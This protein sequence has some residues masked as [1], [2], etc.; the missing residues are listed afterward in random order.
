M[1]TTANRIMHKLGNHPGAI[2]PRGLEAPSHVK[3]TV[4]IPINLLLAAK[5]KVLVAWVANRPTAIAWQKRED[6]LSL[7][8]RNN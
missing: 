2:R 1:R 3:F 6:R 7:V 8:P 5:M 4:G